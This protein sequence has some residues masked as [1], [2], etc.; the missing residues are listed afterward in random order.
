MPSD[1]HSPAVPAANERSAESDGPIVGIDLGT[2]NSLIAVAGWSRSAAAGPDELAPRVLTDE[3]GEPM[4]PSAVR[5]ATDPAQQPVV[6]SEAHRLAAEQPQWTVLSV[7]RL[8]GRSRDDAARAGDLAYLGYEVVE[9]P[10]RTARVRLPDGRVL[11]PQEISATILRNLRVRAERALGVPIR[12]A[13]ISVPAYFDDAQRQAT[14]DAGRLAG[15]DVLRIINEPTAAALA[16][17]LGV[18]P[19]R[20]DRDTQERAFNIVVF[21]LGG[22]TF[23]VSIL[24]LIAGTGDRAASADLV[25]SDLFQVLATAGDTHL[26]GDDF[27]HVLVELFTREINEQFAPSGPP[28]SF[29]PGT[30]QALR[31]LAEQVKV[32]LSDAESASVSIDVGSDD[33]AQPR[34]YDRTISR[35]E[36]GSITRHLID[37]A[38]DCCRRALRD[39]RL[40]LAGEPIGAVVMVGGA[41][42]IPA[43]RSACRS[44]FGVDLYT[45]IDPDQAVALGA[46]VQGSILDRAIA[47]GGRS[48]TGPSGVLLD[49]VPLSLGV[50]TVGGGVAKL[51]VRN[52]NVPARAKEMFSTSVDGQT[53]IK[54]NI[55]Q[56]EREMAA[57]CRSLGE[58]HLRGIPP[59]PAGIPQVEVEFAVDANGVLSV[60]AV[61]RR[62]GK[63]ADL[64]VVPNHGLTRDEVDRLEQES[65][66]FAREDMIRHRVADLIANARLDLKWIRKQFETHQA[67]LDPAY[68][69]ELSGLIDALAQLT[70]SATSDWRS[71]DPNT[72]QQAK[73]NLDRASVRLHEIAITQ[74]LKA[75]S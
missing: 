10:N 45:A 41:T 28:I 65:L 59:M 50:E 36:F 64:Q 6:G 53:S 70:E 30:R 5:Y 44:F 75:D 46:A 58:F 26:G 35:A 13:V 3:A 56:G 55:L 38:L 7:K 9:G 54:L 63:R 29:P 37:R 27:D 33:R 39:A 15:L 71:V 4:L 20:R 61:E 48:K 73:E 25:Q 68:A 69:V 11:S 49:V 66:A 62:S 8:M 47:P 31:S 22:G 74:S 19:S 24:R 32:R 43:V 72:F 60:Q 57:D 2:T 16:Y 40:G 51:I 17:G 12:R 14:R 67:L 21:D 23:D 42:R 18:L 52:S 34:T 1:P